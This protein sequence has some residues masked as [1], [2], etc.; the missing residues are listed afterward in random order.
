MSLERLIFLLYIVLPFAAA[1]PLPNAFHKRLVSPGIIA[2]SLRALLL[3]VLLRPV[4]FGGAVIEISTS[5]ADGYPLEFVLSLDSFRLGFLLTAELCF[6]FAHAMGAVAGGLRVVSVLLSLAQAF[7]SLFIISNN[8]VATGGLLLLAAAVFFYLIRFAIAGASREMGDRI[9]RRMYS[10]YFLL[11]LLMIV[12]GVVEFGAK[13][14]LFG[15]R[16]GS[17][18]GLFIWLGLV[19]LSIPL[20]P[21]SRWFSMA[22]ENLPEGVTVTLVTFISAV[23]LKISTLFSVVYPDM[24]WKQKLAL[25]LLGISGCAFSISGLFAAGSRRKMLGSLP[26]FFFSLILVSVGVSKTSLVLSAYFTCLFVPVF[27]GLVLYASVVKV[28]RPLQKVF[29]GILFALILGVPGTPVFQIFSGIGARSLDL[30]ISYGIVFGLLWFFY[31]CANVHICRR[32]FVD[33]RPPEPGA[34]SSL[35]SA[36]AAFAGYGVFL[37]CFIVV[38]TQLAGGIL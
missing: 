33:D 27:T 5:L 35:E 37:M 9:S 26:S 20:P 24:G 4:V 7:T 8:A 22:V 32:I 19:V 25:Y 31:F 6:L 1:I 34:E 38:A 18:L 15:P 28:V 21:W 11:G 2:S 3:I 14:M 36:P 23:A 10:L 16:S 29:V 30:G 12:W 17:S 13:D